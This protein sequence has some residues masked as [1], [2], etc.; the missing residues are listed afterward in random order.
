M[1]MF[2]AAFSRNF[3]TFLFLPDASIKLI[4][5]VMPDIILKMKFWG[6]IFLFQL[7]LFECQ[8]FQQFDF[9]GGKKE[10]RREK[11]R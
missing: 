6:F 5:Q 10:R 9:G 4:G 3:N 2:P 1:K 8:S 11:G 7:S